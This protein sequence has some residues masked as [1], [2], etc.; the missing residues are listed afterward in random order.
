M[1]RHKNVITVGVLLVILYFG[2]IKLF[3][4]MEEIEYEFDPLK[5]LERI[6]EEEIEEAE[7]FLGD[8]EE[9]SNKIINAL[10]DFSMNG[11]NDPTTTT[12]ETTTTTTT[13]SSTKEKGETEEEKKPIIIDQESAIYDEDLEN[14]ISSTSAKIK[15]IPSLLH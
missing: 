2:Y 1:I 11:K 4:V 6:Q 8:D 14:G 12:E 10:S 3:N 7:R 13:T 5:E 9:T 15:D